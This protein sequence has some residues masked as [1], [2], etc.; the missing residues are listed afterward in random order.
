MLKV[1]KAQ[2][3]VMVKVLELERSLDAG[4]K[5]MGMGAASGLSAKPKL[6]N[7]IALEPKRRQYRT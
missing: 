6:D 4:I 5:P 7:L 3:D 2:I 1:A